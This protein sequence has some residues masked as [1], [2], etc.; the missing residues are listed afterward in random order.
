MIDSNL[1]R[2]RHKGYTLE[3]DKEAH[4]LKGE[5]IQTFQ[6]VIL[7]HDQEIED[8]DMVG[9]FAE[10]MEQG[11]KQVERI[12]E[13]SKVKFTPA[14]IEHLEHCIK[15]EQPVHNKFIM[16]KLAKCG[17]IE[18]HNHTG[19]NVGGLYGGTVKAW[20]VREVYS[21]IID[22]Y[23]FDWKYYPGSFYPYV[24]VTKVK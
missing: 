9:T 23:K 13:L 19:Q 10:V 15:S 2:Y 7:L 24:Q 18:M 4:P 5:V 16:N 21:N 8:I 6:G 1:I 14:Q 20:Y 17:V 3:I 22:G 12:I 11:I